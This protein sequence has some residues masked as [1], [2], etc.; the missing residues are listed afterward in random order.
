VGGC[1]QWRH[2][3]YTI[4]H[5]H[6]V[7]AQP[8]ERHSDCTITRS[9]PAPLQARA[10]DCLDRLY[11]LFAERAL[12]PQI[13][14]CY[15]AA[16]SLRASFFEKVQRSK[17]TGGVIGGAVRVLVC[18]SGRLGRAGAGARVHGGSGCI[19]DALHRRPAA[20]RTPHTAR[21]TALGARGGR[22]RGRPVTRV[23]NRWRRAAVGR[24]AAVPSAVFLAL[25]WLHSLLHGLCAVQS[26]AARAAVPVQ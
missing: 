7:G 25:P 12:R 20:R 13:L 26:A 10:V 3:N 19:G 5:S 2:S 22:G 8:S 17:V 4:T 14:A 15:D 1:S 9:L 18:A 6:L 24:A 21:R 16:L 11:P 23:Y